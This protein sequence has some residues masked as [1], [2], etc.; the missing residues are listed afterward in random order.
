MA[1]ACPLEAPS[2]LRRVVKQTV[3]DCPARTVVRSLVVTTESCATQ[4][5]SPYSSRSSLAVRELGRVADEKERHVV[6]DQVALDFLRVEGRSEAELVP[7]SDLG[8]RS[9]ASLSQA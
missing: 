9:A 4:L 2:P 6:A 3:A 5:L 7:A 1:R 8:R